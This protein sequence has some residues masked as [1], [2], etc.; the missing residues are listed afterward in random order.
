VHFGHLLHTRLSVALP[1][2]ICL[3]T[4]IPSCRAWTSSTLPSCCG[5]H[6]CDRLRRLPV[7]VIQPL[8]IHAV[9]DMNHICFDWCDTSSSL[10]L[11]RVA[12]S[13]PIPWFLRSLCSPVHV[14]DV[15][16]AIARAAISSCL[17]PIRVQQILVSD[18]CHI[19]LP[20]AYGCLWYDPLSSSC[21][22]L[23]DSLYSL[24]LST[25]RRLPTVPSN[26]SSFQRLLTCL[27]C[28]T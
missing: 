4:S 22:C 12:A 1:S 2:S 27:S 23:R 14:T 10:P 28:N 19:R 21:L 25:V 18:R 5:L 17:F 24:L 8:K 26:A 15:H 11:L 16:P 20:S 6:H 3:P 13:Q 9:C 7:C